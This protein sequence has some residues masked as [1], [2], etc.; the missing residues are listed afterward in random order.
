[1][2]IVHKEVRKNILNNIHLITDDVSFDNVLL[3]SVNIHNNNI[4][5]VSGYSPCFL[6][7]N[8]D[9]EIYEIVLENIKKL[10]KISEK[11]NEDFYILKVG[12]HLITKKGH[13]KK[14][15]MLKCRKTKNKTEKL[16]LT[17]L[18]NYFCGIINVRVD[19][20]L[21][22]FKKD[23]TLLIEPMNCKSINENEWKEIVNHLLKEE[24]DY[25][26]QI[27]NAKINKKKKKAS[28]KYR[29]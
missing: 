26:K 21:Y 16:P 23:E 15:K 17:V 13:Y 19:A 11:Q 18:N 22:Q 8:E 10:Y 29:K 20:N 12:D 1:M 25:K 7:R 28:K 5:T 14:G 6:L 27:E 3:D 2:E 4:H 24:E 9:E